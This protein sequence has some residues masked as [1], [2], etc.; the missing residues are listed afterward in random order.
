M[1]KAAEKFLSMPWSS[2]QDAFLCIRQAL[3]SLA[4]AK[5][6]VSAP[7]LLRIVVSRADLDARL[8][9]LGF[10][11]PAGRSGEGD[12][13][14]IE[15]SFCPADLSRVAREVRVVRRQEAL[16]VELADEIVERPQLDD[17]IHDW[18][19]HWISERFEK[20][21]IRTI[22]RLHQFLSG[23][24]VEWHRR[25]PGLK[26][27]DGR[28]ITQ[29]LYDHA[30]LLGVRKATLP[31]LDRVDARQKAREKSANIAPIE[32]FLVPEELDGRNGENR[33]PLQ[34]CDLPVSN[35]LEAIIY[36]LEG[37]RGM[38]AFVSYRHETE[39]LLLWTIL[40]KKK[41]FSSLT[42]LDY[43]DY[44]N[45]FLSDIQPAELW[46]GV[47]VP[48]WSMLWKP[49]QG[50]VTSQSRMN[51]RSV[52]FA[53]L[54][55]LCQHYYLHGNPIYAVSLRERGEPLPTDFDEFGRRGNVRLSDDGQVRGSRELSGAQWKAVL[56]FSDSLSIEVPANARLRFA[57]RLALETG[58]SAPELAAASSSDLSVTRD[59]GKLFVR[60]GATGHRP[61]R[62]IPL[63]PGAQ[64]A[65]T[66]YLE[67]RGYGRS[68]SGWPH[69]LPL[70]PAIADGALIMTKRHMSA[71]VLRDMFRAFFDKAAVWFATDD[72]DF[73]A[74]LSEVTVKSMRN[75][76]VTNCI[77]A[78]M[79][80]H[81]IAYCIG[82]RSIVFVS[83]R[84]QVDLYRAI[85]EWEAF[86]GDDF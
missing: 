73:S 77:A 85:Q 49:F 36:W 9:E 57:L 11:G 26:R 10:V 44:L 53:L 30:S 56:E 76:F 59:G 8:R 4:R 83:S 22:G 63:S 47:R 2:S 79:A 51:A 29:W 33:G 84:V 35:D 17:L 27:E 37:F 19:G 14:D 12:W 58:L 86:L 54:E 48:R 72:P 43:D 71:N 52:L 20:L 15:C 65:I 64:V 45:R 82:D 67:L 32:A 6:W 16:L 13:A 68:P 23:G 25:V 34:R 46:I 66:E 42:A 69:G 41:A 28:Y 74:M 55:Y 24:L 40:E 60:V 18:L 1:C 31:P 62:L 38:A 81:E 39:R 70:I 5:G 75:A 80:T 3:E 21:G 78:G 50:Q 61:L 7:H